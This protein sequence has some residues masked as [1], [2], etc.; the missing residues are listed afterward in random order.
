MKSPIKIISEFMSEIR[1]WTRFF[2]TV[3]VRFGP[4]LF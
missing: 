4:M 3:D 1:S 2:D